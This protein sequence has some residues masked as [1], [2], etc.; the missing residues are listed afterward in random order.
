MV[1]GYALS[2][3]QARGTFFVEPGIDVYEGMV[4]GEHIRPEDL[5]VNVCKTK[6]LSAVRTQNYADDIRMKAARPMTLDDCIEFLA[7]DELME[8]TPVALRIRKRVLN[9]EQRLKDVKAR[10]RM[11][12]AQ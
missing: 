11:M 4:V 8:V 9:T 5:A 1:T 2:H 10:D 6:T 3:V 12:E 7:E